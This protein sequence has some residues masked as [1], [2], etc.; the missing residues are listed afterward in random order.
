M[1]QII[2]IEDWTGEAGISVSLG[3]PVY[4]ALSIHATVLPAMIL[5]GH[6][7]KNLPVRLHTG[8][9]LE[10]VL[11]VLE[12]HPRKTDALVVGYLGA[13]GLLSVVNRLRKL[14]PEATVI[15]DPAMGDHGRLYSGIDGEM[16]KAYRSMLCGADYVLPNRYEASV[17]TDLPESADTE[18]LLDGLLALGAKHALITGVREGDNTGTILKGVQGEKTSH[19]MP[20]IQGGFYGTGDLFKAVFSGLLV[21]GFPANQALSE[22]SL[23]VSLALQATD[24]EMR[25]YGINIR[26]ALARLSTLPLE[27]L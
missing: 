6:T 9:Y 21:L 8:A 5:S 22:A 3:V 20:T 19:F 17:L 12:Q 23:C 25:L 27:V 4:S 26:N 1:K 18:Q 2:L 24:K 13:P 15:V 14:Y 11:S 10:K 16:V 7:G